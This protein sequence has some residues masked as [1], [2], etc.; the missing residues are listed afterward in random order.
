[1]ECQ[2]LCRQGY[3]NQTV[4]FYGGY[5]G[6]VIVS[7]PAYNMQLAYF[8][9]IAAYLVLCGCL[10]STGNIFSSTVGYISSFSAWECNFF[11][12]FFF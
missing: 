7:Q 5:N 4:L 10:L 9:T 1:M 6:E 11:F 3:F 8:F 2:Y 12:F